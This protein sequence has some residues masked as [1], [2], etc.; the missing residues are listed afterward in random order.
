MRHRKKRT[1]GCRGTGA[2][3]RRQFS[4]PHSRP[5]QGR[6]GAGRP[7]Y[8]RVLGKCDGAGYVRVHPFCP[9]SAFRRAK[10]FLARGGPRPRSNPLG[11]TPAR[12]QGHLFV[13]HRPS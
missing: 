8:V 1:F 9:A 4:S 5:R 6:L 13:Q 2:L 7:E 11:T 3:V 12:T 10:L